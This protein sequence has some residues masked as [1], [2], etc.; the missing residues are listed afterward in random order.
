M[1]EK[2]QVE[3]LLAKVSAL[4]KEVQLYKDLYE[5]ETQKK[6]DLDAKVAQAKEAAKK[7]IDVSKDIFTV[8]KNV[9]GKAKD[10]FKEEWGKKRLT[11]ERI[12]LDKTEY[13]NV[14]SNEEVVKK[15]TDIEEKKAD[16]KQ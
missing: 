9:F 7:G 15:A 3:Q 16:D 6:A 12:H 1:T 10:S 4:E 13:G 2:E 5:K 8:T 14:F 11:D